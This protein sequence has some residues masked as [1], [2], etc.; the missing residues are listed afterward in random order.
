[1]WGG[2]PARVDFVAGKYSEAHFW[3]QVAASWDAIA[4]SDGFQGK[5]CHY[6]EIHSKLVP[7][8]CSIDLT[9]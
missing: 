5:F 6:R 9:S 8:Q 1:M 7:P 3:Q 4:S 2:K